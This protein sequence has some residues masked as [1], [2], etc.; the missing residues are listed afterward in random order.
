MQTVCSDHLYKKDVSFKTNCLSGPTSTIYVITMTHAIITA[1]IEPCHSFLLAAKY[2]F[3]SRDIKTD[4]IVYLSA[5]S[6]QCNLWNMKTGISRKDKFESQ[7]CPT[8][9]NVYYTN[10][11]RYANPDK[12]FRCVWCPESF[13]KNHELNLHE[14]IHTGVKPYECRTCHKQFMQKGSLQQHERIHTGVKPHVC[15]ICHKQF[16]LS[17]N[18]K[19]HELIH[20]GVKPYQCTT[21]HK[22]FTQLGH[23]TTHELLHSGVKHF[24][25]GICNKQFK[26]LGHLKRHTLVHTGVKSYECETCHKQFARAGHLKEHEKLHT[27]VKP[28]ECGTCHKQFTVAR[29]LKKHQKIHTKSNECGEKTVDTVTEPEGVHHDIKHDECGT[30]Q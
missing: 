16:T 22:H 3:L 5:P 29:Y 11:H 28:F 1:D 15:A 13:S 19:K 25:C 7:V 8:S 27:G 6:N 10:E 30:S 18:L 14:V 24:E 17:G 20:T 12:P 4:S 21:C 2:D 9:L 26:Q 23:L